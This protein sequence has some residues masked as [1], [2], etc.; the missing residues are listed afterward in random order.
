[1]QLLIGVLARAKFPN[2]QQIVIP[3]AF[4]ALEVA[5]ELLIAQIVDRLQDHAA[6]HLEICIAKVRI[7]VNGGKR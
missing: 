2:E 5:L 4:N 7:F 1:M 6:L 3:L